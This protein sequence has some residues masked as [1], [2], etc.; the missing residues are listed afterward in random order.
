MSPCTPQLTM[1][2]YWRI[3]EPLVSYDHA[4]DDVSNQGHVVVDDFLE[5]LLLICVR[6]RAVVVRA[7]AALACE[8]TGHLQV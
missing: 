3:D 4:V 8:G 7:V 1:S 6:E 2:S 5:R